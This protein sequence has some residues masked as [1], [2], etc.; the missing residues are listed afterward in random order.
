MEM[1]EKTD[2]SYTIDMTDMM[3]KMFKEM[4]NVDVTKDQLKEKIEAM[5]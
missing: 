3:I 5:L 2:M 1:T 4:M